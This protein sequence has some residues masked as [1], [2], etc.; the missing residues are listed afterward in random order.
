MTINQIFFDYHLENYLLIL[1]KIFYWL[2]QQKCVLF[3]FF[4]KLAFNVVVVSWHGGTVHLVM[5]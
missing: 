2:S 3:L 5:M 1:L 4:Q